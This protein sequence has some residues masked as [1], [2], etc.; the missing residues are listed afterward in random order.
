MSSAAKKVQEPR[1]SAS[2]VVINSANQVL[3]VERKSNASSF[4][5]MHVF[6]GGNF[7]PKQDSNLQICAIRELFEE[8]GLV[9]CRRSSPL[10]RDALDKA[11]ED[12]HEGRTT[13]TEFC[14]QHA[15]SPRQEDLL[16]LSQWITPT[17]APRRFHAHFFAAFLDAV[18]DSLLHAVA[19][20]GDGGAEVVRAHWIT[21]AA[22]LSAQRVGASLLMPPQFYILTL[23]AR[24][25]GDESPRSAKQEDLLRSISRGPFAQRVFNPRA[26]GAPTADGRSILTYE[27]DELRG[28]G[29]GARHRSL[30]KFGKGGI[31]TEIELQ[32]N[33]EREVFG[34]SLPEL[35]HTSKL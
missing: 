7:D 5:G 15:L 34:V 21:P 31:V 16:P 33:I 8:T 32:N 22:A 11:R 30:V 9:F 12:V 2:I 6:P 14:S 23:L 18:P 29:K 35:P 1:L 17:T 4:A 24:I 13:F 19:P 10:S 28:G 3:L 27:G 20:G 25:F 26:A